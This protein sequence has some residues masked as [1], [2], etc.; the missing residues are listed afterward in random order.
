[1]GCAGSSPDVAVQ[2]SPKSPTATTK[3]AETPKKVVSAIDPKT[4]KLDWKAI[5]SAVRWNKMDQAVILLA[6][7]DAVDCVDEVNG[8]MPIHIAAQN[9]HFDMLKLLIEKK[10]NVNG[11]NGKGN[12]GLH[13]AIS[14]EYYECAKLLM[15]AGA[16]L[17]ETNNDGIP[18]H[19]G[20]EGN[21]SLAIAAWVSAEKSKMLP[22]VLNALDLCESSTDVLD[23]ADFASTGL[24]LKKAL[25]EKWTP[26]LQERFRNI[27][28]KL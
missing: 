3:S 17:E 20:L 2:E 7:E 12:T 13:M 1:M 9:G 15:D 19:K 11:K 5:Q 4:G 21:K 14:Y 22:D 28:M 16:S 24:K 8:N 10:A 23:K 6:H 27:M 18:A 25:G 26:A